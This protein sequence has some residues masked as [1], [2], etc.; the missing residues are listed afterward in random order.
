MMMNAKQELTR[1]S[2][3]RI[4]SDLRRRS[5]MGVMRALFTDTEQAYILSCTAH[6][7]ATSVVFTRDRGMVAGGMVQDV[8][9]DRCWH[10]S[11]VCAD[12]QERDAWLRAFFGARVREVWAEELHGIDHFRL[13]CDDKWKPVSVTNTRDLRRAHLVPLAEFD[14]TA[15]P[16]KFAA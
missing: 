15:I 6:V 2:F 3:D 14:L 4:A 1:S 8:A 7:D 5:M 13:F 16:R 12:R 9:H 10:L 11:L